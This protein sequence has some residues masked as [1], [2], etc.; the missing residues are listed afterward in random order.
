MNS[1]AKGSARSSP[2]N[3]SNANKPKHLT[4]NPK[5]LL[6]LNA[7]I[8]HDVRKNSGELNISLTGSGSTN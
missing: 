3:Q 7:K 5:N 2:Q 6:D 8:A 1:Q 4:S